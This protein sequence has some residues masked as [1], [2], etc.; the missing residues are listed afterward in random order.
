MS[1]HL[2]N[3]SINHPVIIFDGE[4]HLCDQSVQFVLK[5]DKKAIFRFCTLQYA[6]AN[7]LIQ[8]EAD[9][10]TLLENNIKYIRS[11]AVI[12]IM[13]HLGG[14]YRI[15]SIIIGIIPTF[16]A[17]IFYNII[18]KYRYKWFGKYDTCIIPE[19]QWKDRF[20]S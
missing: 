4:C 14:L 15:L 7:N 17:D 12:R 5:R 19:P 6:K 18:A 9:S 13:G 16:I 3:T 20:I 8:S 2:Y 10:V 1:A 11:K